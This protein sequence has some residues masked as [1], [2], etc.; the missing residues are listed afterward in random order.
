TCQRTKSINRLPRGELQPLE[1]P[2]KPWDAI[3][4]DF[5]VK[6]PHSMGYDSILVIVDY[7][8]KMAHFIPTCEDIDARGTAELLLNYIWKLHGT[9][10]AW[11]QIE[12]LFSYPTL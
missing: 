1:T 12:E 9:P 2:T 8:T 4:C 6:L 7:F 10:P 3:S 11:F 5:I